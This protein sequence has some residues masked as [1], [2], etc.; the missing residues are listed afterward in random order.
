MNKVELPRLPIKHGHTQIEFEAIG[1]REKLLGVNYESTPLL[2]RVVGKEGRYVVKCDRSTRIA[3]TNV[4]KRALNDMGESIDGDIIASNTAIKRADLVRTIW[5]EPSF[6]LQS[7]SYQQP[8]I[9][10]VGFG[11]GRHLLHL[12]KTNP[13][14][15]I[16]GIEIYK[17]SIEQVVRLCEAQGIKNVVVVDYDARLLLQSIPSNCVKNLYVHFPVPWEGAPHRRV[18]SHHFVEESLRVLEVG[19]SLQLRTDDEEYFRYSLDV[20]LGFDQAVASFQK[21]KDAAVVSKYEDR[22]RRQEKDIYDLSI[23]ATTVCEPLTFTCDFTFDG[24]FD[25]E[26]TASK[27]QD[28][29]YVDEQG[30]VVNFMRP[31]HT[32]NGGM[33]EV[34]LGAFNRPE[35]KF[36]LFNQGSVSYYPSTPLAMK[37][38][39]LAHEIIK[40]SLDVIN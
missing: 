22:W 29:P 5:V 24:L 1:D 21:N 30:F 38:N 40:G 12:A 10:E 16:V 6:F 14:A 4:I 15:L 28:K 17:P 8:L 11:S 35:R 34:V 37:E 23:V 36:L 25:F 3:N 20:V 9:V 19:G 18:I 2:F 7:S 27:L 26:K 33:I 13:D 39:G 31:Y 32:K